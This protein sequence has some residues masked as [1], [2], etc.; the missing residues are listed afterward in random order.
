MLTP[1]VF[2]LFSCG[3]K[4]I[5]AMTDAVVFADINAVQT[6]VSK[7][8]STNHRHYEERSDEAIHKVNPLRV[9]E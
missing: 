1:S 2:A 6:I 7:L 9:K 4:R 5:F 8:S 3:T